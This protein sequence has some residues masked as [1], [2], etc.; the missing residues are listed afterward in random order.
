MTNE[1]LRVDLVDDPVG[2]LLLACSEDNQL[3]ERCELVEEVA[4]VRPDVEERVGALVDEVDKGLVQVQHKSQVRLLLALWRQKRGLHFRQCFPPL[5]ALCPRS[6]LRL[7]ELF[8]SSDDIIFFST[9]LNAAK[10]LIEKVLKIVFA[11]P[12][13]LPRGSVLFSLLLQDIPVSFV[14]FVQ[15]SI[16]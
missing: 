8:L 6:G 5:S 11:L 1:P 7:V 4:K 12:T 9:G 10:R 15:L 3:I 13:S 14:L 2:I 16:Q